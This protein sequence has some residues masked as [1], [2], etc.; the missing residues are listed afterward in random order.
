MKL[1]LGCGE[2]YLDDYINIDFPLSKHTVIKNVADVNTDILTLRYKM[3]EVNEIRL[4]HVFEHFTR[5]VACALLASWYSWLETDGV[6][7]IE[8]PN[9]YKISATI[10]NPFKSNHKKYIAV[11]H[12][13]GSH[14]AS[15]AVHCEGY[16]PKTLKTFLENYGFNVKKIKKNN[17]KGTYNFEIIAEKDNLSKTKK[18]FEKITLEYLKKFLLDEQQE[19][20]LLSIWMG[21][22]EKQL[23]KTWA[24]K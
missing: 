1:H 13:F 18:D 10:F 11:R 20:K 17:Y 3:G 15:W 22:Y 5:P 8:V 6:L 7:H 23:K 16:T 14:E 9:L 2:R 12:S 19:K 24:E 21:S 4:H